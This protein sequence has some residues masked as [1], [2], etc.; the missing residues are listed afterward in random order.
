MT[1]IKENIVLIGGGG[2]CSSV[3]DV[4]EQQGI[5]RIVGIVDLKE[6]IGQKNLGYRIICS[7]D[8]LPRLIKE[9]R[10]YFITIGQLKTP[11][12]RIEIFNLLQ[13]LSA[14][15]PV[16]ISPMAFVSKHASIGIGTVIMH[17]AQVN[18]NATIGANCIINSKALIEHDAIIENHCHIST[19]A[20]ING[21][22]LIG[23]NSF[24]GSGVVTKQYIT[25]P[26]AS[27]VKANI[28]FKGSKNKY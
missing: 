26:E 19:G 15:L 3:I 27:F 22:V 21:G 12:R 9:Y 25:V 4:I 13:Q 14:Q 28:L 18:A 6:K 11:Q 5:Y 20:I 17:M 16:I 2:H 23:K 1:N 24:V 10:N 8:D 7:D